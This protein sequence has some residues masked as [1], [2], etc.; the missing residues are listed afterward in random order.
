LPQLSVRNATEV[1]RPSKASRAVREQQSLYESFIRQLDDNVG[2][3]ELEPG[4]SIR[5]VKVRLRRAA[6]RLNLELD[7]WDV[8]G[9][10]YFKSRPRRTRGVRR[11][12]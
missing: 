3:L 6:V 10:V 7:V 8:S 5:S 12:V 2:E 11:N 4:E 9:R 1:P